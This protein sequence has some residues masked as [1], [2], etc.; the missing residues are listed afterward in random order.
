MR[1]VDGDTANE[2]KVLMC[3]NGVWGALCHSGL[4]TVDAAVICVTAGYQ[5]GG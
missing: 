1:L 3:I 2:G 5:K 4:S